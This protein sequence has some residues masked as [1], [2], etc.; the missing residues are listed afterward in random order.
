VK[1]IVRRRYGSPDA[2]E[3]AE[4][5][6][7]TPS[8]DEVLIRVRAASVNPYDRH[9][10]RGEPRLV[11]AMTGL[12]RPKDIRLGVDVAGEV[13]AAGSNVGG[14]Q[15]GDAVFGTARGAFA[16]YVCT[17]KVVRKPA[18]NTFEEAAAVPIAGFTA[19][20]A[21]R[22]TGHVRA[23]ERVL[24]NGAAGGVGSFAVQIAKAYGAEVT[25]VCRT[26]N[27]DMVRSIGADHVVDYT[28]D[29]FTKSGRYDLIVDCYAT[30]PLAAC[31][32]AL[33]PNGRYVMVGGPALLAPV[34]GLIAAKLLSLGSNRKAGIVSAKNNLKDLITL[35][36]WM[37]AGKLKPVIDRRYTLSEVPEAIRYLEEGHARGKLVIRVGAE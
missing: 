33:A 20:Q 7:P 35:A 21:M 8:A 1:A 11:R 15:P 18:S 9:F 10:M 29:D 13:E 12:R 30:R 27:L 37:D 34:A 16:E 36:E 28:R 31:R 25:G 19:L 6:T 17:S 22:D 3:L 23:G 2:L 4:L 14:L 5:E 32:R 24:I 26:R